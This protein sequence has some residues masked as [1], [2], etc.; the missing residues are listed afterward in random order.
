MVGEVPWMDGRVGYPPVGVRGG[1]T[2]D[3][4]MY[5]GWGW[6]GG[7][8]APF[9]TWLQSEDPVQK[10]ESERGPRDPREARESLRASERE[11]GTSWSTDPHVSR[12]KAGR[13]GPMRAYSSVLNRRGVRRAA[14]GEQEK[15][16]MANEMAFCLVMQ[17][18]RKR[19]RKRHGK[20]TTPLSRKT[21]Q[22]CVRETAGR[23][24]PYDDDDG[25]RRIVRN[26]GRQG[27]CGPMIRLEQKAC[28]AQLRGSTQFQSRKPIECHNSSSTSN[29]SCSTSVA[30]QP[31]TKTPSTTAPLSHRIQQ[32]QAFPSVPSHQL[33]LSSAVPSLACSSPSFISPF[34]PVHMCEREH[35]G[36][37]PV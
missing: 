30:Q 12:P 17:E 13:G 37:C 28:L 32:N 8:Q 4:T 22:T 6:G 2:T 10:K 34:P 31:A 19:E 9:C 26:K 21:D 25:R 27:R 5:G 15:K 11:S 16:Q 7:G 14:G 33:G 35:V 1:C 23:L 20:A 18:T 24:S 36:S 29:K 3:C